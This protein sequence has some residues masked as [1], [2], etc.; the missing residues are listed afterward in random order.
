MGF[1]ILFN[2]YSKLDKINRLTPR[3]RLSIEMISPQY[4]GDRDHFHHYNG[5]LQFS[6]HFSSSYDAL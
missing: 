1:H 3:T 6:N 4:C 2:S 5:G